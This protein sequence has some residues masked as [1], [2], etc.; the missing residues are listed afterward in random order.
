M[1]LKGINVDGTEYKINYS[2]IENPINADDIGAESKG[3]A[4]SK[5]S[6]HNTSGTAHDDIRL[7]IDAITTS[8]INVSDIIDNLTTNVSNKPLSAA[9]GVALKTMIDA[10]KVNTDG[11]LTEE[12][13]PAD[14][15][16]TGDKLS[17]L[18]DDLAEIVEKHKSINL[19]N[20]DSELLLSDKFI[21]GSGGYNNLSGSYASHPIKVEAG[22]TYTFNV[23][24]GYYGSNAL[25]VRFCDENGVLDSLDRGRTASNNGDGS[26]TFTSITYDGYVCVNVRTPSTMMF[27]EGT[28]LPIEYVAYFESHTKIKKDV[29]PI[30]FIFLN[31]LYG[32]SLS[33]NGDS[34]CY[35]AGSNGGYGAL[36]G[37]NN[38]MKVSNIA[39]T[40]GTIASGT[41]Y[42]GGSNRHWIC[43]TI[44]NM[45]ISDYNIVEGGSND[46][47]L[48]VPLGTLSDGYIATLDDTTFYGAMESVCKQMITRFKGKKYGFLIVHQMKGGIQLSNTRYKAII[49]C[50]EKWG[51]PY[52]DLA[53]ECPPLGLFEKD[54]G[55]DLS[56]LRNT[57]TADDGTGYGDGWHPNEEC[58]RNY[59]VPKIEAWLRTL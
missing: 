21:Q 46:V 4:E 57:Y 28:S 34:I 32:K 9:Q 52:K 19:F 18:K 44:V 47:A 14:A 29:L 17:E 11:T 51:V 22:K 7:L 37:E 35:G 12:G 24:T 10:I 3:T 2:A 56:T 1:G 23:N 49:D 42:S 48:N 55:N 8:K 41:T 40:G 6:E 43:R 30:D 33:L 31:P 36:I 26:A 16:A 39:L 59:Y 25:V 58:Y 50:C 45:P 38:N 5:V 53:K 20:K 54:W 27:V 15:K 13:A